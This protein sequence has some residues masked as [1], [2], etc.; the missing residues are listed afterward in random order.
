[1][2]RV[3]LNSG[4]HKSF[5][6]YPPHS[7]PHQYSINDSLGALIS[8][9]FI[10]SPRHTPNCTVVLVS[11][12]QQILKAATNPTLH[13]YLKDYTITYHYLFKFLIQAQYYVKRKL[14]CYVKLL[15]C[16]A[17]KNNVAK[18]TTALNAHGKTVFFLS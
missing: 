16:Q 6:R 3:R 17:P 5:M 18:I 10:K 13:Q 7:N 8:L 15:Y 1:M 12:F 2:N 14:A 4:S 9:F 11:H